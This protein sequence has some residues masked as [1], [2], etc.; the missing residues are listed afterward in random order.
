MRVSEIL[1]GGVEKFLELTPTIEE[2]LTDA[3]N[4][5]KVTK[6]QVGLGNV[7][8]DLQAKDADF[9]SHQ[10]AA[11]LD[12]PDGSVTA[13]KLAKGAVTREKLARDSVDGDALRDGCVATQ[14]LSQSVSNTIANKVTKESGMGLS[15]NSF[16]NADKAKLD[17]I[18]VSDEGGVSVDTST[19]VLK[20]APL[21]LCKTGV[22]YMEGETKNVV[23][24]AASLISVDVNHT[25]G[26]QTV[27]YRDGEGIYR[28][29]YWSPYYKHAYKTII[30]AANTV[31][32][33]HAFAYEYLAGVT[34]GT[35]TILRGG[36]YNGGVEQ[37]TAWVTLSLTET[38]DVTLRHF[39][40]DYNDTVDLYEIRL[41]Y[42]AGT[43][44]YVEC[45][46]EDGTKVWSFSTYTRSQKYYYSGE[47]YADTI[48]D[49]RFRIADMDTAK[50]IYIAP[51]GDTTHDHAILRLNRDGEVT[52]K[53][54]PLPEY[55]ADAYV[56][57][58]IILAN[59]SL[60]AFIGCFI[61]RFNPETGVMTCISR[62]VNAH[63][64]YL[65]GLSVCS[66]GKIHLM[67]E[68]I[69]DGTG[70]L[71]LIDGNH[72]KNAIEHRGCYRTMLTIDKACLLARY[73]G[74]NVEAYYL[75]ADTG[76]ITS[77]V[78]KLTDVYEIIGAQTEESVGD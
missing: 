26:I 11:V 76:E 6:E 3:E 56:A 34:D 58:D 45:F 12:H 20:S 52:G 19:L 15:Q 14:H 13:S 55:F 66:D 49:T 65:R 23:S 71:Y 78:Y 31:C 39:F 75:D 69:S 74:E 42:Y 24:G 41:V 57:E 64:H 68:K 1:S 73:T 5:H 21:K 59:G 61:Y 32:H 70:E 62:L 7:T 44:F 46:Y 9:R 77:R 30:G 18:V 25:D 28:I 33:C 63:T 67:M 72:A 16:T 54:Y 47:D 27:A 51:I 2:H 29:K 8:N 40:V 48:Y 60:Y 36:V 38:S 50:N 35:V 53:Y 37:A 4:P 43:K 22:E 17:A 10:K